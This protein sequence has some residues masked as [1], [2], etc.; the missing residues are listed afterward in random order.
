MITLKGKHIYLKALELQDCR[1]LIEDFEPVEPVPTEILHPEVSVDAAEH[2]FDQIQGKQGDSHFYFGIFTGDNLLIGDIQ[3]SR[4]DWQ[5]RTSDLGI[6][7]SRAID[8]GKGYGRE[9]MVLILDF[10]FYQ[11]DLYRVTVMTC[12]HNKPMRSLAEKTGFHLEGVK[13]KAVFINGK[14]WDKIIYGILQDEW[15]KCKKQKSGENL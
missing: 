15:K 13:R 5:S 12:E 2:W 1:K 3:L 4:I 9:A 10:A 7:F 14:R 11:L 6:G 8:R